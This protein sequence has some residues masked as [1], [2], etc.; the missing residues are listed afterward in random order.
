MG[1]L[2]TLCK[3]YLE[4]ANI[5]PTNCISSR[6]KR[7]QKHIDQYG[8]ALMMIAE[9]GADPKTIAREAINKWST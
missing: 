1:E 8:L 6:E 4:L 3:L 9:G 7:L 2:E 5:V